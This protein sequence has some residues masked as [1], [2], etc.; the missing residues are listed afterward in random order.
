MIETLAGQSYL[1]VDFQA[2][3]QYLSKTAW[4]IVVMTLSLKM[5]GMIVYDASLAK[6]SIVFGLMVN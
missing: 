4:G 1:K 3:K 6:A 2:M 5:H